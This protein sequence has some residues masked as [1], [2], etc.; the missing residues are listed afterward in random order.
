LLEGAFPIPFS[1]S[2]NGKWLAFHQNQAKTSF[3][4]WAA[5]VSRTGGTLRLASLV[6]I[7]AESGL[8][9]APA[10][11][12]DGRWIA[13]GSARETGRM[14]VFVIPFS[15]G[16]ALQEK[17]WQVSTDGG[18]GAEWSQD[19]AEMFFRTQDNHLM[20]ATVTAKGESFHTEPPRLWS[21][22]RLANVDPFPSFDVGRDRKRVVAIIDA[23]D[24]KPD[25]THLRVLLN[26]DEE[27]RH[28]R[29]R[30]VT[31]K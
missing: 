3:D 22:R 27:L 10:I 15:P 31:A 1:F 23:E 29:A 4:I 5:E 6:P 28:Q 17:K 13:Y 12:P 30:R 7:V 20:A 8:Q 14:E 18:R 26:V 24:T 2:R 25:D 21:T 19:G 11:S 16:T 9:T